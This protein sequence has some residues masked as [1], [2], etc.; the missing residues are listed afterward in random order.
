MVAQLPLGQESTS[1]KQQHTCSD[2]GALIY[3]LSIKIQ[4]G[5]YTQLISMNG[6]TLAK[7][8]RRWD[9]VNKIVMTQFYFKMHPQNNLSNG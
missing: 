3:P 1:P 6:Q 2:Q 4:N 7:C 9:S 5:Q 8:F